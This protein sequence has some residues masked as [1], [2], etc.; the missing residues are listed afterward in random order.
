MLESFDVKGRMV[1]VVSVIVLW[2]A[3][4]GAGAVIASQSALS[5][6]V[7]VLFASAL[8]PV[9]MVRIGIQSLPDRFD[10]ERYLAETD[11]S[12]QFVQY[13]TTAVLAVSVGT[14]T[15]IIT[16]RLATPL[17]PQLSLSVGMLVAFICSL[18]LGLNLFVVLNKEYRVESES[19]AKNSNR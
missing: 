4:L 10:F 9:Y 6:S 2:F 15:G 18:V 7:V 5:S 1:T 17:L 19:V 12:L 8:A 3:G 14:A 11:E 13:V 16:N